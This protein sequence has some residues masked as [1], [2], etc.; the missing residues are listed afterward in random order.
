MGAFRSSELGTDRQRW[1]P[2]LT[3][4]VD[5]ASGGGAYGSGNLRGFN[6]LY[7]SSGYLGEA[8]FLSLANLVLIAPGVSLS[9][10]STVN[11]SVEYGFARR[12]TEDDA[13]YGGGMRPYPGTQN[14]T[15]QDVGGLLRVAASWELTEHFTVFFD[16]EHLARG[17]VLKRADLPSG[18]YAYI[19]ATFRY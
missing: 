1:K 6:Q 15:E 16:Y 19:G 17:A 12:L 2:R 4:H 14:V 7:A 11:V 9:P 5:L 13:V 18:S 10:A 8:R 3:S